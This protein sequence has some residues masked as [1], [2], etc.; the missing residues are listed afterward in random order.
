MSD[1][2]LLCQEG[3][4][5]LSAHRFKRNLP[6]LFSSEFQLLLTS[7]LAALEPDGVLEDGAGRFRRHCKA[8]L[9]QDSMNIVS[10]ANNS[11]TAGYFQGK[12]NPE[13]DRV[14]RFGRIS[15]K[16]AESQQIQDLILED[17]RLTSWHEYPTEFPLCVGVSIIRFFV[18]P[19]TKKSHSVGATPNYFHQDGE[20]F[21]FAHLLETQNAAG[22]QNYIA[23]TD[24]VGYPPDRVANKI[25]SQFTMSEFMDSYAIYDPKISHHVDGI[26]KKHSKS[27][28]SRT[29]LLIDF[30][31]M[32]LI[33][34]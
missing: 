9:F 25:L 16:F 5:R 3:F 32:K 10:L 7:E 24:C 8:L 11:S 12:F 33:H 21:T 1:Q 14:R 2:E 29:V 4:L 26:T 28:A 22:G 20:V 27:S 18:G 23:T 15:S 6:D 19:H 17:Y 30:T 34:H 31:P 13:I